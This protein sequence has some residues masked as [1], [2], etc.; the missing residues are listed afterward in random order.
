MGKI[1]ELQRLQ[2]KVT[3]DD[4]EWTP[5]DEVEFLIQSASSNSVHKPKKNEHGVVEIDVAAM[6]EEM[7]VDL[8]KDPNRSKV[9]CKRCHGLQNFGYVDDALRPGW[10]D[11][12]LLSQKK[13]RDLL[14]PIREK[15]AVIIALVDLFDFAG[16]VLPELDNI[17]GDN[18]VILVA[19]K[20]DLMPDKMGKL[21]VE[22]WVRRELQYMGIR[23]LANMGGA[24][25]LVSCKTGLGVAH[26]LD[27]A[28]QLAEEMDCDIYVIG[29]ANAG[30]STLL[31]YILWKT[32]DAD[33]KDKQK[34]TKIRAGNKNKIKGVVT[35]SP[36]P[37][38][39]LKFIKVDL[40]GRSLYDTPGL[41]VPGTLTQ[42]LTPEELKIV[43]PKK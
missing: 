32:E 41:L 31:N 28:R 26:M 16:S 10:T 24:V 38:T 21:R 40:G 12:P 37:G 20:A 22:N 4:V 13:F 39:T 17:A 8:T 14:R 23:S 27:K 18:P 1:Q 25:Q 42:L 5:E 2:L 3:Q 35:T 30:K 9:I 19:N 7:G 33:E 43:V 29:A 6:A 11:E 34:G 36:L 15:P